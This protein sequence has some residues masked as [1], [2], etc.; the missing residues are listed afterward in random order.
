MRIAAAAA[1]AG[2]TTTSTAATAAEGEELVGQLHGNRAAALF[3]LKK[4]KECVDD[5]TAALKQSPLNP[6]FLHRRAMAWAA[7]KET[8]KALSD[9]RQT[10][11]LLQQ[12][13]QQEKQQHQKQQQQ[14]QRDQLHEDMQQPELGGVVP[15]SCLSA[16]ASS[17]LSLIRRI[18]A[19]IKKIQ[20]QAAEQMRRE[21]QKR[22]DA[23]L[24]PL[25]TDDCRFPSEQLR[26]LTVIDVVA[27]QSAV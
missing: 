12:Q 1:A 8:E 4:Y 10:L 16:A 5:C 2:D 6:K 15:D 27:S 20:A 3:H 25:D 14:Q 26:P 13:Q 17:R 23:L 22:K 7:Q 18:E 24:R 21:Q 11:Q 19:E 9:L